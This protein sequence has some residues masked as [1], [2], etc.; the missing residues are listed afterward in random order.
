MKKKVVVIS[1][2][3]MDST[4]L[5]YEML[6]R[7]HQVKTLGFDYGQRHRKELQHA[8]ALATHAGVPFEVANLASIGPLIAGESSQLRDDID[9]PEGHYAANN[10]KTTVVPN[11][12]MIMLSVATGYA[13]SQKFDA[14][15]YGAHAGDHDVYPDCRAA[16]TNALAGAIALCDWH[17]IE[18]WRPFVSLTKANICKLA[19]SVIG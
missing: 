19:I 16:F 11:R 5:M 10:M 7:G 13:I 12:N 3:G 18:L 17:P 14:V 9:V 6:Q 8:D 4:T 15:A 1:S 2:G